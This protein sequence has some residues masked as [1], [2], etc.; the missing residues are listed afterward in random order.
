MISF[1][2]LYIF[3]YLRLQQEVPVEAKIVSLQPKQ[4][5][6]LRYI[7]L[8]L[9]IV[10]GG[11]IYATDLRPAIQYFIE[12][13]PEGSR[14]EVDR[15]FMYSSQVMPRF[16]T[17]RGFR[18][19]WIE[20]EA[21]SKNGLEMLNYIRRMDEHG[22]RPQDYHLQLIEKYVAGL[23]SFKT[24]DEQKLVHL[25]ILL[26]DAFLLLGSQMYFGKVDP[27]KEGADWKIQ[28]KEPGLKLDV[29][30]ER[31]L[32]NNNV[33]MVLD[34]LQPRQ[35]SYNVLKQ[36]LAFLRSLGEDDWPVLRLS[37]SLKPGGAETVVIGIRKRLKQLGYL[38]ADTISDVYDNDLERYV[39]VFQ[40][41]RGLGADGVI[42]KGTL[43]ALNRKPEELA[44]DVRVNMERL[45][46]LP[47]NKPERFILVN[48]A[49]FELDLLDR[50]DTIINMRAIVGK[51]YRKTP[52]F[53]RQMTYLVFS[54]TWTVPPTIL[55]NDV[56]PELLKGPDYLKQKNMVLLRADGS[57]V[58]WAD[59]DWSKVSKRNF[60]F[61]VRQ[62][63][64]PDNALGRVK[65]MFPNEYNV[66]IHDTPAKGLFSK[67]GRAFSSGCVRVEQPF[68]LAQLLLADMPDWTSERIREAMNRDKE[69]R[70]NLKSPIDV[71]L[72]YLTAWSDGN[73]RVHFRNDIYKRDEMVLQALNQ[74]PT[75]RQIR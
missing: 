5:I 46:W 61:T 14:Y 69:Q 48:I 54:P 64:G 72:I 9:L 24:P 68:E 15:E 52:V 28:R 16:Y 50:D 6:M 21:L 53:N 17:G 43:A 10:S 67:E 60:P 20:G 63:P 40:Y 11:M 58:A 36:K 66:Y 26:T 73:N 8:Y 30:L 74:K 41:E 27:H 19:A 34:S 13:K 23:I 59:V 2:K 51:E 49:N 1:K 71:V 4:N 35:V 56:I 37:G 55:R 47:I 62:N 45:R 31:A 70:V 22:L 33:A 25:D 12:N 44:D 57:E 65:F 7:L 39:K 18:P 3:S 75:R 32:Y 42:G 29:K 38:V